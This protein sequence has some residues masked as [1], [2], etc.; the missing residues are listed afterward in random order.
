[1]KELPG[2]LVIMEMMG[3][4]KEQTDK[5]K[6]K[7]WGSPACESKVHDTIVTWILIIVQ[8]SCVESTMNALFFF[9]IPVIKEQLVIPVGGNKPDANDQYALLIAINLFAA[10]YVMQWIS[11][12]WC[13]CVLR[14]NNP[15]W[16]TGF[17][18]LGCFLC[19]FNYAIAPSAALFTYYVLFRRF[20]IT[21]N[22][23]AQI[24]TGG[25][26]SFG[27][28]ARALQYTAHIGTQFWMIVMVL[29]FL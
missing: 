16:Y 9:L 17:T 5:G 7:S 25:E 29:Y 12:W 15:Y 6:L 23:H 21:C 4:I 28:R 2:A 13:T 11:I 14:N 20:F 19:L 3:K 27:P 10:D 22:I 1:M 18:A 8:R 24:L 26:D